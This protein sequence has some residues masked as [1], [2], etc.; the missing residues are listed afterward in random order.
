M[1]PW[2]LALRQGRQLTGDPDLTLRGAELRKAVSRTPDTL[3]DMHDVDQDVHPDAATA[4]LGMDQID[5]ETAAVDEHEP[6]PRVIPVAGGP[7][8]GRRRQGCVLGRW[9]TDTHSHSPS[10]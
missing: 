7:R 5:P 6:V 1:A 4:G 3:T 8:S 10:L 2:G 9:F